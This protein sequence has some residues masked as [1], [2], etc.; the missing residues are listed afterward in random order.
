MLKIKEKFVVDGTGKRVSVL[1]DAEDYQQVLRELEELEE[2]RAYDRA[3]EYPGKVVP[4]EKALSE[5]ERRR[6]KGRN[7]KSRRVHSGS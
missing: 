6:S 2:I 4:F 5:I 1:L 3:K 7:S